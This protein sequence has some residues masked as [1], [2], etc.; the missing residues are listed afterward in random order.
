M[1]KPS[2]AKSRLQLTIRRPRES[3]SS[4]RNEHLEKHRFRLLD[5]LK[6]NL[7]EQKGKR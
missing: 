5:K 7:T 1:Q 6:Q 2:V 4:K 3:R